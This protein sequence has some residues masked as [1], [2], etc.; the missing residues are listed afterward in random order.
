MC[1]GWTS[2]FKEPVLLSE[3][4]SRLRYV[5]RWVR[6]E[7]TAAFRPILQ[8]FENTE[9]EYRKAKFYKHINTFIGRFQ[10]VMWVQTIG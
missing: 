2:L 1:R 5:S 8:N 6:A 9:A 10:R 4:G 7:K 3:Y